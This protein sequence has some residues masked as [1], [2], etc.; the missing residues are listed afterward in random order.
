MGAAQAELDTVRDE[1]ARL[2]ERAARIAPLEQECDTLKAALEEARG[3]AV[4]LTRSEAE[5]GKALEGAVEQT[6]EVRQA[7]EQ[8]R[9]KTEA[10]QRETRHLST[11]IG[12]LETLLKQ[13]RT[14]AQEKL[15][16]LH[17]AEQKL[18]DQFKN[19]ANEI[20]DEKSKKFTEQNQSN[21]GALLG[22]LREQIEG[23]KTK[24]EQ[25]YQQEARERHSLKDQ[26]ELLAKGSAK[27]SEEAINLVNALKGNAKTQGNWGE[28]M[29]EQVLDSSGLR[30]GQEYEV[31]VSVSDEEGRRQQ[32]DVVVNLPE[33]KRIV[34]DAKVSLIA[35]E[36]FANAD[37][38]EDRQTALKEHIVS[39]RAHIKGLSGKEYQKRF[40]A[41]SPDFVLMFI[42]IEP[43]FMAAT[44]GDRD[45]FQEAWSLN[46]VLVSPST[47]LAML[48]TIASVWR[49]ENQ[50]LNAQKIAERGAE[51]Y[52]R[53][54]GFVTDLEKVGARI[55]DAQNVF[56]EAHK[57]LAT[58]RGN[59]I[60]Q[61]EMLKELGVKPSKVLPV[62]MVE[63]AEMGAGQGQLAG[64]EAG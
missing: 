31:Q 57:K 13:E 28:M 38:E 3:Q 7:L 33:G 54:V 17:Q 52:D 55:R 41:Q 19:L 18:S 12:E 43:A 5:R 30:K 63:Q 53:L 23:F 22:P 1:R 37:S 24:V 20:L 40:G 59:V 46:I 32:P 56:D 11:R 25:T 27:I 4:R 34:I 26:I 62:A 39:L 51:L 42:P 36:R 50:N 45:L 64:P 44:T 60:R 10:L 58:G 2:Q 21:L 16:L 47:L 48:R 29:L 35:Y 8:E 49:Q 15:D 6:A 9:E 61:A 14:Q